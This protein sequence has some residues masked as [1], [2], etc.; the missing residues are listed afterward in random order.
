ME[1]ENKVCCKPMYKCAIC[2]EVYESV[3]ERAQCE[4]ACLEKQEKE[5]RMAEEAKKREEQLTRKAE[6]DAAYDNYTEMYARYVKL[7]NNYLK[8]YG[9]Y[10]HNI[11][12]CDLLNVKSL[13]DYLF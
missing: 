4:S 3:L 9:C 6:V 10:E 2:G 11:Y 13:C 8:D 7:K 12:N 1:V 5:V